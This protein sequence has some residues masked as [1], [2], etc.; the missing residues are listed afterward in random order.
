MGSNGYIQIH[1]KI[2]TSVLQF[3]LYVLQIIIHHVIQPY[4]HL[5]PELNIPPTYIVHWFQSPVQ[6]WC[7]M[8]CYSAHLSH[9][10]N[11]ETC[12][13]IQQEMLTKQFNIEDHR[14]VFIFLFRQVSFST[15]VTFMY[16]TLAQLQCCHAVLYTPT[17]IET[18]TC[19]ELH[20]QF[21]FSRGK[22][23]IHCFYCMI[24]LRCDFFCIWRMCLYWFVIYHSTCYFSTFYHCY[25]LYTNVY[26]HANVNQI[27]TKYMSNYL[28]I[29]CQYNTFLIVTNSLIWINYVIINCKHAFNCLINTIF[30]P[31]IRLH[32]IL[33]L[34][35][36]LQQT[37]LFVIKEPIFQREFL[38]RL[39]YVSSVIVKSILGL[40]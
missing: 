34:E 15:L 35:H 13:L 10:Y 32:Y 23:T 22:Y 7:I 36:K 40:P 38:M 33:N 4:I 12:T 26:F 20:L 14:L 27:I 11:R 6:R 24:T 39:Y 3:F 2:C 30:F 16:S 9:T 37:R 8:Q 29:T 17:Y 5:H 31:C 25:L 18:L 1:T 28:L 21:M 19:C